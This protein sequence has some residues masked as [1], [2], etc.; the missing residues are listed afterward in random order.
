MKINVVVNHFAEHKRLDQSITVYQFLVMH[1]ITDDGN[2]NDNNRDMALPF[3][4]AE[5][6]SSFNISSFLIS[7]QVEFLNN[8]FILKHSEK[9]PNADVKFI[10][11]FFASI[12]QPPQLV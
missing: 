4:S 8:N 11:N 1:Y 10:Y 9:I 12:W 6:F 3:K 7:G 2:Q 5:N